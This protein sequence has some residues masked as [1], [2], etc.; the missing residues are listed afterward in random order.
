MSTE[1]RKSRL[2]CAVGRCE[3]CGGGLIRDGIVCE[4]RCHRRGTTKEARARDEIV[5]R[6]QAAKT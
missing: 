3:S 2:A 5:R 4:C 1:L 6:Q